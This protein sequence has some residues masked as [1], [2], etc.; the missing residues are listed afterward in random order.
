MTGLLATAGRTPAAP[1][2][3][4]HH[5][6][7]SYAELAAQA[8]R[9]AGALA[10]RG[11]GPGDR[12][13]TCLPT[14]LEHA[15]VIHGVGWLG[16]TVVPLHPRLTRDELDWQLRDV[17][18]RLLVTADSVGELLAVGSE[19]EPTPTEA[20]AHAAILY[21]SGTSG[22]P[23][24]VPLT[25]ANF[26]ASVSGSTERLGTDP[27]DDWLCPLPLAHVAGL[28]VLTRSAWLGTAAT[29]L[30]GFDAELVAELLGAGRIT[31]A[32]LVPTLL[33]R[34]LDLDRPLPAPRLRAI[35]L[36]GGPA[37]SATLE[38]A[39]ALGWP[40]APSYGLT[41]TCSQLA[42]LAPAEARRKAGTVGL[43]IAGAEVAVRQGTIWVRGPMVMAGYL[44]RPEENAE[45]FDPD[46]WFNTGDLGRLD[47]EGYLTIAT[48]REDLIVTGG[49]NVYPAEVEA[50][51]ASHP[52]VVDSA[53]LGLSD[54]EWGQRVTAVVVVRAGSSPPTPEELTAHLRERLAPFKLPKSW[55]FHDELPRTASGK[56]IRATLRAWLEGQGTS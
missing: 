31:L 53:V 14:T 8:A 21:T 19:R 24:P 7:L 39:F 13:A 40:I 17:A 1:A 6:T 50:A 15:V 9:V 51:L 38:R 41:E 29:L 27:E 3:S 33:R 22:R 30:D 56:L 35:L 10:Q 37:D 46:G 44:D 52:A 49:E 28:A 25:W 47:A 16:G 34:L 11:L 26:Q 32:S 36:G 5:R 55:W 43:P 48:R 23:K 45:R 2:L 20:G 54:A 42:T 4:D 18:P 12:V